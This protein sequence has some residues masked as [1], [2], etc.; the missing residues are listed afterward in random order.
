MT[1]LCFGYC[2]EFFG[3]TL[4][5]PAHMPL[6]WHIIIQANTFTCHRPLKRKRKALKWEELKAPRCFLVFNHSRKSMI[7][8]LGKY[9]EV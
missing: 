8:H 2:F 3:W 6:A 1:Y 5:L 9:T 7:L 4:V